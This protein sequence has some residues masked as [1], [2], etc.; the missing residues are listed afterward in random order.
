LISLA[1]G[2]TETNQLVPYNNDVIACSLH[3]KDR[4]ACA[5]KRFM[6]EHDGSLQHW[7]QHSVTKLTSVHFQDSYLHIQWSHAMNRTNLLNTL[8]FYLSLPRFYSC[9]TLNVALPWLRSIVSC[10]VNRK[11]TLK[12]SNHSQNWP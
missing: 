10:C 1:A 3:V 6:T 9:Q 4:S 8:S 11:L 7:Q 12:F 5:L 2:S